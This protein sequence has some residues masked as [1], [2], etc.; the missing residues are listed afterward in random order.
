[1][2][3]A[4][5]DPLRWNSLDPSH[6]S[7]AAN[8]PGQPKRAVVAEHQSRNLM[9]GSNHWRESLNF[10]MVTPLLKPMKLCATHFETFCSVSCEFPIPFYELTNWTYLWLTLNIKKIGIV[11]TSVALNCHPAWCLGSVLWSVGAVAPNRP[12][13]N[14]TIATNIHQLESW[15]ELEFMFCGFWDRPA[16][17]SS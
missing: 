5:F 17:P 8:W 6:P 14:G 9:V 3:F 10:G 15:V 7:P 13:I 2:S 12:A 1:M 11:P 4:I 16:P